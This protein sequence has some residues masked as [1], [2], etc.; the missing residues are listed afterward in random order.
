MN[1]PRPGGGMGGAGDA[2]AVAAGGAVPYAQGMYFMPPQQGQGNM[3]NPQQ[4]M[5][6]GQQWGVGNQHGS[7]GGLGG[8]GGLGDPNQQYRGAQQ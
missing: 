8:G 1:V 6:A 2:N 4:G 3:V 5:Q 7:L